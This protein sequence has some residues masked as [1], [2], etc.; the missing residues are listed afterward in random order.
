MN[1]K[2]LLMLPKRTK[3]T[4]ELINALDALR[5]GGELFLEQRSDGVAV[6]VLPWSPLLP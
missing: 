4:L 1:T 5:P 3:L 2:T 6:T